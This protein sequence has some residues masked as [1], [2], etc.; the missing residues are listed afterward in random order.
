MQTFKRVELIFFAVITIVIGLSYGVVPELS[1]ERIYGITLSGDLG[2][3]MRTLC[4]LYF[5]LSAFWIWTAVT[6]QFLR[7]FTVQLFYEI[8]LISGR[9]VSIM[10][11]G[12]PSNFILHSYFYAEIAVLIMLVWL[13]RHESALV[14]GENR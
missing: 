5:G 1:M 2:Y 11:D 14:Q 4:G 8:G 7:G 6:G 3:M 9:F 13:M 10:I 12:V